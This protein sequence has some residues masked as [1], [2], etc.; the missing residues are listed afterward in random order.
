MVIKSS[1]GLY[2]KENHSI[3]R[4]YSFREP[5]SNFN[6]QLFNSSLLSDLDNFDDSLDMDVE[7]AFFDVQQECSYWDSDFGKMDD[8]EFGLTNGFGDAYDR[9]QYISKF[10][11]IIDETRESRNNSMISRY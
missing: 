6:A 1:R 10:D 9:A 3:Q 2:N 5:V 11:H 7:N 8:V 4:H